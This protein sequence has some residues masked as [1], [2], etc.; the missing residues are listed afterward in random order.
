MSK[1][2]RKVVGYI[3]GKKDK[4]K[5]TIMIEQSGLKR[6]YEVDLSD[7]LDTLTGKCANARIYKR[8]K[9]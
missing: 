7:A 4:G 3:A 6:Y 1:P 5:A 2:K 8:E 9:R